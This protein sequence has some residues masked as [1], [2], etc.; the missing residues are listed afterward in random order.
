[1]ILP[2][3]VTFA[4]IQEQNRE[5][6]SNHICGHCRSWGGMRSALPC[7]NDPDRRGQ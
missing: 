3:S 1:M 6:E 4:E 5:R 2:D 7:K